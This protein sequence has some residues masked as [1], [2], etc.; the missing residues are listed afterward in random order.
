M[1]PVVL[2]SAAHGETKEE[3]FESSMQRGLFEVLDES[4]GGRVLEFEKALNLLLLCSLSRRGRDR[5]SG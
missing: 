2:P 3:R 4:Q 5:E 1:M